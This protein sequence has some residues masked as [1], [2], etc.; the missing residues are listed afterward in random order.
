MSVAPEEPPEP[1]VIV[2]LGPLY[3]AQMVVP[4]AGVAAFNVGLTVAEPIVQVEMVLHAE[5]EQPYVPP[6]L[7]D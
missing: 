6:V 3:P 5:A 1:A 7:R 2:A 4:P